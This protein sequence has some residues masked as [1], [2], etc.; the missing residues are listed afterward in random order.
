MNLYKIIKNNFLVLYFLSFHFN[1][2]ASF[3]INKLILL[4]ILIKIIINY[5]YGFIRIKIA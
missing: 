5:K 3:Q 4:I 2:S 1:I